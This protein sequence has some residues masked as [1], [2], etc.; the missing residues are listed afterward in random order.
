MEH[1]LYPT[2][3]KLCDIPVRFLLA[4]MKTWQLF[5]NKIQMQLILRNNFILFENIGAQIY[6]ENNARN[7]T[8]F[9]LKSTEV[10]IIG[11]DEQ[12]KLLTDGV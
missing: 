4:D 10:N 6:F 9:F 1:Y 12:I 5:L 3:V 7:S 2:I 11:N 8:D